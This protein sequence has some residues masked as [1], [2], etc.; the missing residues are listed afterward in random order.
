MIVD[1]KVTK[2]LV[3]LATDYTSYDI[4]NFL[5]HKKINL[6]VRCL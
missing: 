6:P 4:K 5:M 3:I 2:L 1:K